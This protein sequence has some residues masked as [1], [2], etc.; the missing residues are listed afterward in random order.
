MRRAAFVSVE[1]H[2][3]DRAVLDAIGQQ[4]LAKYSVAT[5]KDIDAAIQPVERAL[6]E[7]PTLLLIDNMESILLPPYVETS[8]ALAAAARADLKSILS[9]CVRLNAIGE[10]RLVFTSREPLPAPFDGE[11]NRRELH[12]LDRNDAVRFVERVLNVEG[13][14]T[15]AAA[16]AA[17]ESIEQLVDSVNCHARTLTLLAPSLRKVGADATRLSLTQLMEEMERRYPGNR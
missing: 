5:F 6:K 8:D 3:T 16:N 15:G 2:S 14:G 13:Q 12:R 9:L 4:L 11:R 10:T 7:Q 1:S 17:R